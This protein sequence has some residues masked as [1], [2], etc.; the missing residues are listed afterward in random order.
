[1][2][3]YLHEVVGASDNL[4]GVGNDLVLRKVLA[5]LLL[6]I[7][8]NVISNTLRLRNLMSNPTQLEHE[9]DAKI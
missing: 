3:S 5:G 9:N 4:V 6:H 7:V 8:A 1:M 2:F